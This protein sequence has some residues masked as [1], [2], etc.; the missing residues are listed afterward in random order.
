MAEVARAAGSPA[1]AAGAGEVAPPWNGVES[2]YPPPEAAYDE[3]V[4][5]A[6]LFVETLERLHRQ[7]GTKF[8]YVV[9]FTPSPQGSSSSSCSSPYREFSSV[10]PL[11]FTNESVF[12][13][14]LE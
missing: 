1:P 14:D 7:M 4:E 11:D 12:S 3:V 6:G 13:S 8:M 2:G 5:N 9:G 10:V